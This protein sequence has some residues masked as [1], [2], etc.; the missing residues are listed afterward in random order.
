[1]AKGFQAVG[2]E[3]DVVVVGAGIIGSSAAYHLAKRGKNTVLL[4]QFP[5]PHNR[6]S[7]GG[8][9]RIIRQ[10]NYGDPAVTPIMKA[11]YSKWM[12]L[13]TMAD[14]TLYRPAP[15]L[16]VADGESPESVATYKRGL[17]S[18]RQCGYQPKEMTITDANAMYKTK[19][20]NS[21]IAMVDP[22]AGVLLA[23]KCVYTYQHLFKEHGGKILDTWPVTDIVPGSNYSSTSVE[24]FGPRGR[25]RARALVICPGAWAGNILPLIGI[26]LPLRVEKILVQ[27]WRHL[28]SD[29]PEYVLVDCRTEDDLYYGLPDTDYPGYMKVCYHGGPVVDPNKRDQGDLSEVRKKMRSYISQYIPSLDPNCAIEEPCM[30]TITP[31]WDFVLDRHPVHHNIVFAAGFSGTGFKL[32]PV[33]GEALARLTCGEPLELDFSAFALNRFNTTNKVI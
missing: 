17:E 9:S 32:A 21:Y 30:Y 8:H 6:G 18:V 15:L 29:I 3:C 11:A 10:A 25:I 4:D 27:Y 28:D 23:D 13:Q 14:T 24:I 5:I 33:C 12:E 31:D 26:H 20:P 1:M 16:F 22:T 2:M 7:S 19:F